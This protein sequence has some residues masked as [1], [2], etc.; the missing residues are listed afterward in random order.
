MKKTSPLLVALA[1]LVVAVPLAWGLY[2]S[3]RNSK[4]LF[5][6]PPAAT[7]PVQMASPAK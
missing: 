7:T 5:T 2:R 3:I 4:P 6:N 1:Y